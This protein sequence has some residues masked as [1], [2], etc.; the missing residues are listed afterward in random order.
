MLFQEHQYFE[1]YPSLVVESLLVPDY[2]N[3][4]HLVG[5]IVITFQGLAK[6]AFPQKFKDFISISDMVT[7]L[8]FVISSIIIKPTIVRDG[9]I[10]FNFISIKTKEIDFTVVQNFSFFI[11]S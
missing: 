2:L 7:K 4:Y 11:V 6:A 3:S 1:F 8:N 9:R 10:T 5:F